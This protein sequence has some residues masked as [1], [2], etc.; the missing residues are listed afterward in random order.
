[1]SYNLPTDLT[2]LNPCDG[3]RAC[4]DIEK[5][6]DPYDATCKECFHPTQ[7]MSEKEIAE[8]YDLY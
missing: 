2:I 3:E 4:L 5:I 6:Y 8:T 7:G 1:M